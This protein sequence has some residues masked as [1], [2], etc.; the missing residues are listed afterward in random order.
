MG[1]HGRRRLQR[2]K[3]ICHQGR[4]KNLGEYQEGKMKDCGERKRD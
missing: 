3:E 4:E 2:V 1:R